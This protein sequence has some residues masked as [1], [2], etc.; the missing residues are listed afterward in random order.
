MREWYV[1]IDDPR[2]YKAGMLKCTPSRV[3]HKI[4]GLRTAWALSIRGPWADRWLEYRKG[5]I[6]TLTHGRKEVST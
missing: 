1:G 5:R 2:A 6:V 4:E 3:F